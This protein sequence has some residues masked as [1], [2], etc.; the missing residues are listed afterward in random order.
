M[1]LTSV[2]KC[3]YSKNVYGKP[4]ELDRVLA[5]RRRSP[6]PVRAHRSSNPIAR[7]VRSI[8]DFASTSPCSQRKGELQREAD[9]TDQMLAFLPS[10]RCALHC[11]G[12]RCS[13]HSQALA[14]ILH[15]SASASVRHLLALRLRFESP[16]LKHPF[17]S[18]Y[19]LP[20]SAM[21][22]QMRRAVL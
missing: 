4:M 3:V 20:N 14:Q 13:Q 17:L 2:A 5:L 6:P 15:E 16:R 21:N 22:P 12:R 19:L 9:G 18:P 8:C 11:S 1:T 7:R 10:G